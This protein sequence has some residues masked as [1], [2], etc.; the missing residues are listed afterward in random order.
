[1]VALFNTGVA[2]GTLVLQIAVLILGIGFICRTSYLSKIAKYSGLLIAILFSSATVLSMVYQYGFGYEPCL[3]CWYQRI[4]IIPIAIIAW[5]G[6][7]KKEI[8][9]QKQFLVLGIIGLLI[10]LFHVY[11]DVVPG[12]ASICGTSG[13]SCT[14][15]YVYEFGYITIPVMSA[16]ILSLGILLTLI[17]KRYSTKH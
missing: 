14:V 16:T 17:A 10:A 3:L 15:R 4:A 13:V 6:D 7:L 2:F 11:I 12:A 8:L 5:T 9:L 1:M